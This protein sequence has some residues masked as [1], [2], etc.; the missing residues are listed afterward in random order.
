MASLSCSSTLVRLFWW[1]VLSLAG[2][3]IA[4]I[5]AIIA[6]AVL[7]T[8]APLLVLAMIFA[9]LGALFALVQAQAIKDMRLHFAAWPAVGA[10]CWASVPL[11]VSLALAYPDGE[12]AFILAPALASSAILACG[13]GA[14]LASR[15]N[16]WPVWIAASF[17][18]FLA[19][20]GL[21]VWAWG[22]SLGHIE[23]LDTLV[24][25]MALEFAIG[26]LVYVLLTGPALI[27]LIATRRHLGNS[28]EQI[29]GD[30]ASRQ[31][32]A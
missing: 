20:A 4:G 22:M 28:A 17:L 29:D 15:S 16:L 7:P 31:H 32:A 19:F 26:G 21:S 1:A 18:G 3:E 11:S 2:L 24:L 12:L 10:L 27:L 8:E 5:P 9:L 6:V 25:T 30:R 13:Q 14:L 23:A